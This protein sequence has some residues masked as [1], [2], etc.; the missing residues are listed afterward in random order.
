MDKQVEVVHCHG[1]LPTC[2]HVELKEVHEFLVVDAT[3]RLETGKL[4]KVGA[5]FANARYVLACWCLSMLAKDAPHIMLLHGQCMLWKD[6]PLHFS[7]HC[8]EII[9]CLHVFVCKFFKG[10]KCIAM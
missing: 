9:V 1:A 5:K 7:N 8:L 2:R 6:A 4:N 3:S 10:Y